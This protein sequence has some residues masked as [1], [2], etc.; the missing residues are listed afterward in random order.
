MKKIARSAIL[1]HSAEALYAIVEDIESY[2]RFL[3]WCRGT[4]VERSEAGTRAELQ[5][6]M[7]GLRQSFTTQNE[8]HPGRAI[9]MRLVDGPFRSF[10][11]AWRFHPLRA[12]ACR[13]EFSMEYEF[14]SAAL[15]GLLEPVFETIANT[16]VDAFSRRADALHGHH[17]G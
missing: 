5:V 2:P 12:D 11:A 6:G 13:V 17:P 14:A 1:P 8:N 9:D 10:A 16:M 4:R 7:R 3:P 15:A